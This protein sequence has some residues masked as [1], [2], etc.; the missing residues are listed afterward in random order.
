MTELIKYERLG[1]RRIKSQSFVYVVQNLVT[2]NIKVG[3]S[4]APYERTKS[5]QTGC[6]CKLQLLCFFSGDL[7][8]E[9]KIHQ[10]LCEYSIHGEWFLFSTQVQEYLRPFLSSP[11][12]LKENKINQSSVELLKYLQSTGCYKIRKRDLIA[13][14]RKDLSF[15]NQKTNTRLK[16]LEARGLIFTEKTKCRKLFVSLS[17]G[18]ET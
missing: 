6:D 9:Q 7:E 5:M 15:G 13:R 11:A 12:P 4:S 10:D 16:D 14:I 17:E 1:S 18:L 3:I 2:K 8:D